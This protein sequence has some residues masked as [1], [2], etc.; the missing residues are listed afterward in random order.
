M[1]WL[2]PLRSHAQETARYERS[3]TAAVLAET[4][5]AREETAGATRQIRA[6]IPEIRAFT[7]ELRR[8]AGTK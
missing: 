5:K 3:E 8:Q 2:H 6:L 7:A 1:S 4:R